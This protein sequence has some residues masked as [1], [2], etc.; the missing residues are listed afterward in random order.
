MGGVSRYREVNFSSRKHQYWIARQC[1][2]RT[3]QMSIYE[4]FAEHEIEQ[5]SKVVSEL[6][7]WYIEVLDWV[8]QDIQSKIRRGD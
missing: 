6:L 5:E 7:D 1:A 8:V 3:H 2:K 4:T